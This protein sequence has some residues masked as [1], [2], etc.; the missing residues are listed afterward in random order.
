MRKADHRAAPKC[1]GACNRVSIAS[2]TLCQTGPATPYP[3]GTP[4]SHERL[5]SEAEGVAIFPEIDDGHPKPLSRKQEGTL[6]SRTERKETPLDGGSQEVRRSS[7]KKPEE[8]ERLVAP[9]EK[10][11]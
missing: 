11:E 1:L 2:V 10:A 3:R 5:T 9:P 4:E 7:E 6:R 8:G